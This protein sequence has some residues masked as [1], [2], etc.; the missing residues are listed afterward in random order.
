[1]KGISADGTDVQ[2]GTEITQA[3]I[4]A[5]AKQISAEIYLSRGLAQMDKRD[6][7]AAIGDYDKAIMLNPES[8]VAFINRGKAQADKKALD[9]AIADYDKAIALD[10]DSALAY[11]NRGP[12]AAGSEHPARLDGI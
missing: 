12:I 5:M 2:V 4:N 8:V 11:N 9:A 1:M 7:D 6:P 10:P 3:T